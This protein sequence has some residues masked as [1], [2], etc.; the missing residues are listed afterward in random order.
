MRFQDIALRLI[1]AVLCGGLVGYN[2]QQSHSPAGMRTIML[3]CLGSATFI[4]VGVQVLSSHD[5][6][7]VLAGIIGGI[8]FLGA[9][10][11]MRAGATIKG[12][13]TAAALWASAAAG[14]ACG[15]GQFKIALLSTALTFA[16]LRLGPFEKAFMS[17]RNPP[18]R[19]D[20]DRH[21]P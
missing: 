1:L 14:A 19:R 8:G 10:T 20:A 11:I 15:L 9:G 6:T 13:T 2:R 5:P 17:G 12:I 7:R 3:V 18:P 21:N 4:L 16:I